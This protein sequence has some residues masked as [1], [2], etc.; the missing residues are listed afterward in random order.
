MIL[1]FFMN[2]YVRFTWLCVVL[3]IFSFVVTVR[4][5]VYERPCLPGRPTAERRRRSGRSTRFARGITISGALSSV[6]R[7]TCVFIIILHQISQTV[8]PL[9]GNYHVTKNLYKK[10]RMTDDS[11]SYLHKKILPQ[12]SINLF[13]N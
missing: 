10:T 9:P 4:M 3:Y 6:R 13:F 12:R 7:R 5:G 8:D 11:I 2:S 1:L